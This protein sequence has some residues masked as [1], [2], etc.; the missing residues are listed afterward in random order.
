MNRTFF[1]E[2]F[3]DGSGQGRFSVIDV[4]YFII[5]KY[6]CQREEKKTPQPGQ[7]PP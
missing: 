2:V 3:S 1:C 5:I 7:W 4:A 6:N